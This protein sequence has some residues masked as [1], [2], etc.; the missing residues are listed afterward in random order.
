MLHL[1]KAKTTPLASP[2]GA[3][4]R[5]GLPEQRDVLV[6]GATI[7]TSGPAGK[8]DEH[9]LLVIGGKVHSI[10][11]GL[12]VPKNCTVID[13]RN[14]HVTAGLLD[15]H[16]HT[17]IS[18]GT[19]E[20]T[21]AVT[22]EVRIGDVLNPDDV[23]IYRQL[24]GGLT[25]ANILH[26]S[27]NPIGGRCR[28]SSGAGARAP[29]ASSSARRTRASSS[30][31]A[32]TS[33]TAIAVASSRR[34]TRRRAWASSRSCAIA[35][36]RRVSMRARTRPSA[37]GR[38]AL[39]PRRDLELEALHEILVG[40]RKIHCHSYRQDE[41]LALIRV[42]DDFG[43][44]VRCFQHILEGYKVAEAMA[45]HGATGSSFSDWWAYKFEV[46]DAIQHNGALMHKVGVLVSFNSDSSELARRMNLEA[47]KAVKYG[48]LSES[49]ALRFVTLNPAKQLGVGKRVRIA[50]E[51]QGR[52]LR[53]LE[54]SPALDLI[55]LRADLDRGAALLR[56]HRGPRNA[57]G[58]SRRT[59]APRAEDPRFTRGQTTQATTQGARQ[60]RRGARRGGLAM[61][62]SKDSKPPS[63]LR[64]H[65]WRAVI[66]TLFV[67]LATLTLAADRAA[68]QWPAPKQSTDVLLRGG[69]VHA[70]SEAPRRADVLLRDGKIARIAKSI[71][72]PVGARVFDISGKHVYPG[73]IAANSSLGLVEIESVRATRDY[74]EAGDVTPE[75][76]AEVAVNPDSEWL[77]VTR[78]NGVAFVHTVP[79]GGLVSG[80]SALIR[81]DGWT[82]E[83]LSMRAP[84]GLHVRW[85]SLVTRRRRGP[86]RPE[87]S[88]RDRRKAYDDK[89]AVL[90]KLFDDG[91]AYARAKAFARLE[92]VDRRLE[93]LIPVLAKRVPLFVHAN[94]LRQIE[95]A[96]DLAARYDVRLVIVGGRDAGLCAK[97]LAKGK[98]AVIVTR[99]H[100]L[101]GRRDHDYDAPFV[102]PKQLADAGVEF[103]IAGSGS[104]FDSAN[105]RNLPYEAATAAAY[106]LSRAKALE[107]VTLAPARILGV[108]DRIGSLAK[109]KDAS[110]IVTDGDPLEIRTRVFHLFLEGREV[111]LDNKQRR[112]YRKYSEKYRRL[113]VLKK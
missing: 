34:A 96:M 35:F 53:D 38:L 73:M 101:P 76:R 11:K 62:F 30:L 86:P 27:A 90:R 25:C 31:S 84:C 74:E 68:A 97:E 61:S 23:N 66:G 60:T 63:V 79:L 83:D 99:T 94:A 91:R 80:C 49:E 8:L 29:K 20:S 77:P 12:A 58:G 54:R 16:S 108:A 24:A 33:S 95:A 15:A 103:C 59:R 48:G 41:I 17:A 107:S 98:V 28:S 43:F 5:V 37:A 46:V 6:R 57:Q 93:A 102:L 105:E 2:Q 75:V 13:G 67:G 51:G 85:P 40:E 9:D 71:Q 52:R 82:W 104:S 78:S 19:N 56:P 3:F 44:K 92:V 14:K 69:M 87:S 110:L 26:G 18:A 55:D 50:R 81:L 36:R 109:G 72:A 1:R 70:V 47:A 65:A 4:G 64:G 42:A 21:Q 106:G 32:R 112:L 22:A 100:R 88:A 7:W 45:K 113:G 89:L 10:G 111:D 39:E